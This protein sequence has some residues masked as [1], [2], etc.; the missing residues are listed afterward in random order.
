MRL[1]LNTI[2]LLF[3]RKNKVKLSLVL[4]GYVA[5]AA[6]DT[7]GILAILPLMAL[8]STS[9]S[10][11]VHTG[12]SGQIWKLLGSP[13]DGQFALRLAI[14]MTLTFSLKALFGIIFRRWSLGFSAQQKTDTSTE[15]FRAYLNAPYSEHQQTSASQILSTVHWVTLSAFSGIGAMIAFSG[16]VLTVVAILASLLVV[17]PLIAA[18]V[19]CLFGFIGG[20]LQLAIRKRL[21]RTAVVLQK[22]QELAGKII[23]Q[24][25]GGV[26]EIILRNNPAPFIK[27][28]RNSFKSMS[29]AEASR[30]FYS[31]LPKFIFELILVFSVATLTALQFGTAG[32]S[33]LISSLG[34][35]AAAGF[36]LLPSATRMLASLN[37]VLQA[38][39]AFEKL[40][41]EYPRLKSIRRPPAELGKASFSGDIA[42]SHLE[43][44]YT[45]GKEVLK[46]INLKIKE[47][48]SLAIVGL[49]GAGKSTLVDLLLGLQVPKSGTISCGGIDINTSIA[50]WQ[51]QIGLVPQEIFLMDATLKQNIVFDVSEDLIDEA[52]LKRTIE[53]AQLEDLVSQSDLGLDQMIGD[54]GIRISGGQRQRIG[55]ARA[56]YRRPSILILDEATSA[57]DNQT[58]AKITETI[59]GLNG[60]ITVVVVAHRLSTVKGCDQFLVLNDGYAEAIGDFN[61]VRS[62]SETF[63]RL[64][65]LASI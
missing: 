34:V 36:R 53:L 64:A 32:S 43:F 38:R 57:L 54:R 1:A 61:Y 11:S 23:L 13:N 12:V 49:S 7:L 5:L 51:A 35:F 31:E 22:E 65:K 3:S 15:L 6:L 4:A 17:N 63:A 19:F 56:L 8:I 14:L 18:V 37:G 44:H 2:S 55:I 45:E 24:S 40:C 47:G 20:G 16:E 9:G 33:S 62:E 50:D 30:S 10:A 41:A 46:D 26:K 42:I 52:L 27:D 60:Q 21:K 28:F 29:N 39:P 25:I 59:N 48:S 58:E